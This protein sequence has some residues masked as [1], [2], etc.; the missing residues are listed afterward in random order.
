MEPCL[1]N[2]MSTGYPFTAPIIMP[3]TKYFCKNGYKSTI[4]P[5]EITVSAS[6]SDSFGASNDTGASTI[7]MACSALESTR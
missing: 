1:I 6:F 2:I 5:V 4:G 3:L 7:T